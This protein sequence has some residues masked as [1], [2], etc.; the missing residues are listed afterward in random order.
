MIRIHGIAVYC[1]KRYPPGGVSVQRRHGETQFHTHPDT[2][3]ALI[4]YLTRRW[5]ERQRPSP[6]RDAAR[7]AWRGAD[8]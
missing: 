1:S 3:L 6:A 7:A 4:A 5:Q 8:A 2:R